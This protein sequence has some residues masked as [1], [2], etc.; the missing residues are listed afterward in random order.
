MSLRLNFLSILKWKHHLVG[1]NNFQTG[2]GI[3][4]LKDISNMFG[5]NKRWC[6]KLKLAGVVG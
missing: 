4:H 1:L 6:K 2:P 5:K 3:D